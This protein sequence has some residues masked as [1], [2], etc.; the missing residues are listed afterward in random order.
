[1]QQT[2]PGSSTR[3][4]KNGVFKDHLSRRSC[5][6]QLLSAAQPLPVHNIMYACMLLASSV[7]I[8]QEEPSSAGSGE[9]ECCGLQKTTV[10][11]SLA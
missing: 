1:M 3:G 5:C 6:Q 9:D 2:R 4:G 11:S 7:G 10:L 8:N